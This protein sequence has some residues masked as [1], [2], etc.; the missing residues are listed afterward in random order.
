[1]TPLAV[2][3]RTFLRT[4]AIVVGVTTVF[5]NPP[6]EWSAGSAATAQK[7]PVESA[8]VLVVRETTIL[9]DQLAGMKGVRW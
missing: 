4:S 7:S 1:M 8:V 9:S 2:F 3:I 6:L 5:L